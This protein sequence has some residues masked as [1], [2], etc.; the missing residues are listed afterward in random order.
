MGWA[1]EIETYVEPNS[2]HSIYTHTGFCWFFCANYQG[3]LLLVRLLWD[4]NLIDAVI[5]VIS[6]RDI[7]SMLG[8]VWLILRRNR[9]K[10]RLKPDS[11]N[12]SCNSE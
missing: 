8:S 12:G 3:I 7:L 2:S 1:S 6:L 9:I 4:D 5:I 10:L 11:I